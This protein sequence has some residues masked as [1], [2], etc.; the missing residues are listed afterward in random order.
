MSTLYGGRGGGSD[1]AARPR[2]TQRPSSIS[3]RSFRDLHQGYPK[4]RAYGCGVRASERVALTRRAALDDDMA[5]QR[6]LGAMSGSVS[7]ASLGPSR[8][9]C[10]TATPVQ[11]PPAPLWEALSPSPPPKT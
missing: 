9:G 2:D 8:P 5:T 1:R 7:K 10:S 6:R 4:L 3:A 11:P